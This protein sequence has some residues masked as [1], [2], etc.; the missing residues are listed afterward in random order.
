[1][2]PEACHAKSLPYF[3]KKKKKEEKRRAIENEVQYRCKKR[4]VNSM[5]I[6]FLGSSE[7]Y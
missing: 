1:M 5:Q 7:I 6:N 4:R 3:W 2:S